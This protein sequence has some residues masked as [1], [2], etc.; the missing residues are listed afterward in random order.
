MN[1]A[2]A[3]KPQFVAAWWTQHKAS[4]ADPQGK[5]AT[6]LQSYE[7]ARKKFQDDASKDKGGASAHSPD[8][9]KATLAAVKKEALAQKGSLGTFQKETVTALDN[10][11]RKVDA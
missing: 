1:Q 4:G 7:A 6:A 5:F 8:G 10:Y 2:D 3:S 9:V 11:A